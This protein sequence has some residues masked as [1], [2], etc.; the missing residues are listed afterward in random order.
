M[1]TDAQRSG[2]RAEAQALG[3]SSKS[4]SNQGRL[5]RASG[6]TGRKPGEGGVPEP[7]AMLQGT[8]ELNNLRLRCWLREKGHSAVHTTSSPGGG[9][10]AL[11]AK[12]LSAVHCVSRG[13][14]TNLSFTILPPGMCYDHKT[15]RTSP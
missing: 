14:G 11:L 3:H 6:A 12:I 7:R 9:V 5:R 15:K 4:R 10:P 2:E 13:C 1:L 8:D